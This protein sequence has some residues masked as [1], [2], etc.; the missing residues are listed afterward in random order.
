MATA[1]GTAQ[2]AHWTSLR[3]VLFNGVVY[4]DI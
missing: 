4:P 1:G 3:S 2:Q